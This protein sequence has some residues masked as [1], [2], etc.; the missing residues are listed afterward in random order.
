MSLVDC[1]C[2]SNLAHISLITVAG[3]IPNEKYNS[4]T[5]VGFRNPVTARHAWF[6]FGFRFMTWNDPAQIRVA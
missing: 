5:L 2:L 6:S 1:F 4:S 3:T